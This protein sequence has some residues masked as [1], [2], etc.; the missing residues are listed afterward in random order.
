M[1]SQSGKLILVLLM[2]VSFS[3]VLSAQSV[4]L[5]SVN[6]LESRV[7]NGGDTVY[8]VNF[9]ATWCAPCIAELPYFEQL[10]SNYKDQPLKVL[11]VSLDLKS[12]LDKVVVPFV[13]RNKLKNEIFLLNETNEQQYIDRISKDWSGALP[14]TLIYN[15]KNKSGKL[16]EKE[17]TY[18]ELEKVY[19][20]SK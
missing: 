13:K 2:F 20:S 19:Q 18:S 9:W 14:A 16:Y 5:L 7:K 10:Q 12:K 3:G 8:V 1:I 11:L 15:Q 4:N 17:F 6:Q